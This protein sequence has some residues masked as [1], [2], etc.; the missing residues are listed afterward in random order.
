MRVSVEV[1]APRR[2]RL[3][4]WLAVAAGA[5]A[6]GL[7]AAVVVIALTSDDDAPAHFALPGQPTSLAV[8]PDAVWVAAPNRGAVLS[9]DPDSGAL[10]APLRTGGSPSRLAAGAQSLWAVDTARAALVPIQRD[11]PRAFGAI[12]VGAD[13]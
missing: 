4:L 10:G 8:T 5:I 9:L 13:A 12:P 1:I 2:S 11:P 7:A 6:V 3:L